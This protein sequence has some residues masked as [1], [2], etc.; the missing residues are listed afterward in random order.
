MKRARICLWAGALL[1][2]CG[3]KVELYSGLPERE[4]NDIVS[5]LRMNAIQSHKEARKDDLFAIYVEDSQ[6]AEAVQ[7]LRAQGHPRRKRA[8]L[9]ELFQPSGL[10]PTPFEERVRYIYGLSQ[11]IAHTISLFEGVMDTRVHVVL[12][13]EASGRKHEGKASVYVKYD[14]KINFNILIPRVKKLVSDGVDGVSYENVE[15]LA[16][17][18]YIPPTKPKPQGWLLPGGIRIEQSEEESFLILLGLVALLILAPTA[19]SV[20]LFLYGGSKS[21]PARAGPV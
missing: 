18:T 17:P 5:T 16:S 3:C 2:L 4:A 11:E 12:P 14:Q 1:L 19:M 13:E 6:F 10:V 20:F 9:A 7:L 21:S 15:I 8:N